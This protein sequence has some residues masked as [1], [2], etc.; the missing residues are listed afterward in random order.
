M[1]ELNIVG[2]SQYV[3]SE[4]ANKGQAEQVEQANVS[5]IF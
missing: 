2:E 5:V 1:R 3:N 4:Q